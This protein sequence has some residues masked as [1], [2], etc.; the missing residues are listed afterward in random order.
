MKKV[1]AIFLVAMFSVCVFGQTTNTT[2]DLSN[3][4]VSIKPDKRLITVLTTLEAAGIETS[5]SEQGEEFRRTLQKDLAGVD[6]DL[7]R[8]LKVFVEQY[9]KRLAVRYRENLAVQESNATIQ[10][11]KLEDFDVFLAKYNRGLS[12]E[13]KKLYERRYAS[14]IQQVKAPFI[15]MAH[16]LA[17]APALTDPERSLDLPDDLLEVL[18]YAILVREFYRSNGMAAKIDSYYQKNLEMGDK[19]RPEAREMVRNILDYLHTRPELNFRE[20][21][22]VESPKG[23]KKLTTYEIRNR[24]RKFTIVPELLASKGT[25]NF[26]NIRDNYF[27]I[28]P[29]DTDLS[30]SEVRRAY[31][32]FVLD[33][34]VIKSGKNIAIHQKEI[35]KLL[36]ERRDAGFQVS[37]DPFLAVSRSLVA[38]VDARE[39]QFRKEKA[40]TDQ[41]RRVIPL[42]NSQ[43]EKK[44]VVDKLDEVKQ[45]FAD[46]ALL[47][48]SESYEKGAVLA[49]YFAEKLKGIEDSGFDIASSLDDWI[50]TLKPVEETARLSQYR[51][52]IQRASLQRE[53]DRTRVIET[54]TF[55]ENP[56][57]AKLLKVEKMTEARKFTEA[58][59]ELKKLLNENIENPIETARIYY[60][61]GRTTSQS[62]EGIKD[63]EEVNKR[64]LKAK[65]YYENVFRSASAKTDPGLISSTYFALGKIYEFAGEA[66]YAI[67]IYDA[68]LRLGEVEGGAYQEAFDAKNSLLKRMEN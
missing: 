46:E 39:R 59:T 58:E 67:Q 32:Q 30:S 12:A 49:F 66:K 7:R 41:A 65:V 25:I 2:L 40:A 35:K 63:L 18:D 22:K 9:A 64:L 55:V 28:V 68:A 53:K 14:F 61:L 23:K 4:G 6:P 54:R 10:K 37:P 36:D 34:L 62:A 5:L 44:A 60:S 16:S 21:I 45:I 11:E 15:S 13:D 42:Q 56:L 31:V 3:Y 27:A 20:R 1:L 43:D 38:A 26:L 19:M 51:T 57:T 17:P 52:E 24:E 8:K 33:P 47:Q 29:P 48:L 50:F